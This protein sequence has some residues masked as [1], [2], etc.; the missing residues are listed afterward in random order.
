MTR[1][2]SRLLAVIFAAL[3]LSVAVVAAQ[4]VHH[5]PDRDPDVVVYSVEWSH[6]TP[7]QIFYRDPTTGSMVPGTG[8]NE[9]AHDAAWSVTV[10]YRP[11]TRYLVTAAAS[12]V[13]TVDVGAHVTVDITHAGQ[14]LGTC[15][16][17]ITVDGVAIC[18]S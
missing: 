6:A 5:K 17:T 7:E 10:P 14:H 1:V 2:G 13:S 16:E 3:A 18:H 12:Y 4:H 11:E 9:N 8:I 15:P